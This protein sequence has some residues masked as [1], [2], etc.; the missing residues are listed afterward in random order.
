V[1]ADVAVDSSKPTTAFGSSTVLGV[2]ASPTKRT[3]VRVNVSG[4]GAQPLSSAIL[5]LRTANISGA[6]SSVGGSIHPISSCGWTESTMTFNN[7]QPAIDMP[8]LFTAG[9]VAKNQ[10][11]DFPVT[12]AIPGDGTFCFALDSP[13][14]NGADYK[15]REAA[16]GQPQL[17]ITGSC[18]CGVPPPTTTTTIA[19]ATTTTTSSTTSTTVAGATAAVVADTR[20]EAKSPNTN[21]GSSTLLSADADSEKNTFIKIAASGLAGPTAATLRLT[22]ANADRAD[23]NAGGGLEAVDCALWGESTTT[24]NTQPALVGG[25]AG[26]GPVAQGDTV[27]FAVTLTNGMNCVALTSSSADGVDYNSREASSGQPQVLLP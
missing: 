16:S 14:T 21:F 19:P 5:R 26:A 6:D 24:F 7:G 12:S 3:F 18:A 17:L 10:V 23:S 15:S 27:D 8:V 25:G 20:T 4:L 11:V 9:A 2:D 1:L 22:V 13:S